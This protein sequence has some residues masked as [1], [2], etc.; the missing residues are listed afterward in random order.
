[1]QFNLKAKSAGTKILELSSVTTSTGHQM[2]NIK[3]RT[4]RHCKSL[5]KTRINFLNIK[6]SQILS[7]ED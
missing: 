6:E 1:M 4:L 2:L 5:L 3:N 7:K